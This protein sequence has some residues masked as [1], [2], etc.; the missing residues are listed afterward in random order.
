MWAVVPLGR[1]IFFR[2][3]EF[4]LRIKYIVFEYLIIG[5]ICD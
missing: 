1:N 2:V 4:I 5:Y 3:T